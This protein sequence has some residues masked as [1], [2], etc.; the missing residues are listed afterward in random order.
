MAINKSG[1]PTKYRKP[2]AAQARKLCLLGA[3]DIQLA[4]FF[5]VSE[6]TISLWKVK[7]PEFSEAVKGAKMLADAEVATALFKRATGFKIKETTFEKIVGEQSEPITTDLFKKK[8]VI[9]T[10]VPDTGAAMNWL[11]NRQKELWRNKQDITTDGEPLGNGFQEL[12]SDLKSK[13]DAKP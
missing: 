7:H 10:V 6:S 2:Y 8:V 9:K 3:T 12:L 13:A 5:E 4:E 1:R 11:T